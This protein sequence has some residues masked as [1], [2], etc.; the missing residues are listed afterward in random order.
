[1]LERK[2]FASVAYIRAETPLMQKKSSQSKRTSLIAICTWHSGT[3]K[4][5]LPRSDRHQGL[6]NIYQ[7]LSPFEKWALKRQYKINPLSSSPS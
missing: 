7:N 3:P 1:M 6:P 4:T 5:K 2:S